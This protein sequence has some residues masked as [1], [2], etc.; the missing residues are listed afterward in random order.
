MVVAYVVVA[1][2][3]AVIGGLAIVYGVRWKRKGID[4]KALTRALTERFRAK[5]R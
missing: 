5:I 4:D 1:I 3:L 2:S